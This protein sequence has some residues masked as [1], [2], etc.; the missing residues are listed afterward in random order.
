MMFW[1]LIC[2]FAGTEIGFILSHVGIHKHPWWA[3]GKT[4]AIRA[5]Q[6]GVGSMDY[7]DSLLLME[8][9]DESN[10]SASPLSVPLSST[11]VIDQEPVPEWWKCS[12]CCTMPQDMENKCCGRRNCVLQ[13][14]RFQKLCLDAECLLLC[15][16]NTADIRNDRQDSSSRTFRKAA[17][18][19]YILD[20]H[21]Y[22]GKRKRKVVPSCC[23]LCI[24]R[25]YPSATGIYMGFRQQ[26]NV[27]GEKTTAIVSEKLV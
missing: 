23:V 14:R 22:L 12:C 5:L 20:T 13:T 11:Q 16:K 4:L 2:H 9:E 10:N 25:H 8:P 27:P 17:Y 1:Q 7:V 3:N 18:R 19:N 15:A 21:G 26:W 6:R 24:R